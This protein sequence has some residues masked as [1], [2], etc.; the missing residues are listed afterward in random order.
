[1][2]IDSI[3][4][5][6]IRG[7]REPIDISVEGKSLLLHGPNGSGKSSVERALRWVLID[8]EEPTDE[9]PFT[10]ESSYRRHVAVAPD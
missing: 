5:Q 7:I 6:G 1:M 8:E 3:R 10:T 4:I 2:P 9:E